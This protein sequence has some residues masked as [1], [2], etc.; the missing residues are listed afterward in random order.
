[1]DNSR[2]R[3]L[4]ITVYDEQGRHWESQEISEPSW[5]DIENSIRQL[6][7]FRRP[8]IFLKLPGE[9]SEDAWL[10]VVGG[11]GAYS[12]NGTLDDNAF[13]SYYDDTRSTH[14]IPV[15]TSDQGF[16]PE[17]KH[18]C[19]EIEKV[20]KIARYFVEHGE[21]DPSVGWSK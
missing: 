18:V 10:S 8:F 14:E 3:V 4:D 16:Y 1:M 9:D 12:L 11:D 5:E 6:D 19:Y 13:W 17:E 21:F 2:I 15:W 20:L 7:R